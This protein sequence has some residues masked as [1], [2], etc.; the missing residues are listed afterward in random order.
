MSATITVASATEALS[1]VLDPD[2]KKDLVSLN[3]IRDLE[4]DPQGGVKVR[5]VLTTPACPL[6]DKIR[7]D[8][9]QA[10]EGA[11]ATSIDI[12]M[13]AE[14]RRSAPPQGGG[15]PGHGGHAHKR[16]EGV[17]H[18]IA[19]ASGKGGVGKST[20][21][22]NLA[23]SLA[24]TGASVGLLDADIYGPSTPTM[25]GLRGARPTLTADEKIAPLERYGVKLISMGFMLK[26]DDAVVWRGPMLG[27]AVEQFLFDVH[28]GELDYLIIDLPPGTG[29]VQL[30][31]T[32]YVPLT[33]AVVVTTPQDVAFADVRRAIKMFSMTKT[34]ILG[35]VENMSH[36]E[37]GN[38]NTKHYIYGDSRIDAHAAENSLD[39]LGQLPLDSITAIAA[40]NGEPIAIAAP[41][42]GAAA[43]YA[44]LAG[45][46]AQKIAVLTHGDG[47]RSIGEKFK[48]F[49]EMKSA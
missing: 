49:F 9:Q 27:K 17:R 36:F 4:V 46:I 41:K 11:G 30:S 32:Q 15:R 48:S 21:A 35:L 26:D 16:L 14:V 5:V 13:D 37:C 47:A 34:H 43:G 39:V 2:L 20:V 6:K 18:V 29:D 1:H 28:W 7:S 25:M 23:V 10:L 45:Q 40:D 42:S 44:D 19:V 8:V 12:T 38:C 33:G 3:M 22:T 31:L 24:K